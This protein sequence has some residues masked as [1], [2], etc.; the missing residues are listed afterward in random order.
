M[1][2]LPVDA[3]DR[4]QTT[5]IA[6]GK[7]FSIDNQIDTTTGTVKARALFDNKNGALFPNQFVNTRL[8]VNTLKGVTLVP[9][10]SVQHNGQ[11][12]F[13]YI[14][15]NGV[16]SVRNIKTGI[17][18]GGM[19][20]VEGINPGEIVATSTFD[21]LQSGSKLVVAKQTPSANPAEGVAP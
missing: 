16:V 17:A 8:L 4:S 21:K 18:D 11:V 3:W 9:T 10:T 19:T 5:K 7:M 15:A 12:A 13:L 14:V 1:H 2:T 6:S 20:Q